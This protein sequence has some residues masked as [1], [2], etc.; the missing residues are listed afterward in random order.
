MDQAGEDTRPLLAALNIGQTNLGLIERTEA[1][2]CLPNIDRPF[3]AYGLFR[4]GQLAFIRLRELVSKVTEPAPVVGSLLLRDGLPIIDPAERGHVR[5]VL[6]TFWPERAT[7]AYDY[8][9]AMG[10]ERHY[11]WHDARIDGA[12]ANVLVGQFPTEGSVPCEN[13]EWN[14]WKIRYSR[15]PWTWWRRRSNRKTSM[16]I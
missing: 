4:P 14:G 11:C 1:M 13:A 10:P 15:Q 16:E 12:V 6:L 2:Q 7:E 9:S 8:I 3:F 5:G